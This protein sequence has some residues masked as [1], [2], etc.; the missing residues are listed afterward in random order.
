MPTPLTLKLWGV[1]GSI[2]SPGPTTVR[3]GGNTPCISVETGDKC[4]V[5]DAGTGG[6]I[7]FPAFGLV[8]VLS[9]VF[10]LLPGLVS[11]LVG[12]LL[13]TPFISKRLTKLSG[14]KSRRAQDGVLDLDPDEWR[15]PQE[16]G[17]R[18]SCEPLHGMLPGGPKAAT[19]QE[20][21][22]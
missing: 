5:M 1:R 9:G 10:L 7:A 15:A 11:D 18:P 21:G 20:S 17:G 12:L 3:H 13:L 4:L 2:P 6:A 8:R 19:Q 22:P 14:G 16:R